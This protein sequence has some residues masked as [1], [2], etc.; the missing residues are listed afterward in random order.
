VA[1]EM[2]DHHLNQLQ[3]VLQTQVVVEVLALLALLVDLLRIR[4]AL[5]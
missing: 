4:V 5:E 3:Q 1:A 2:V